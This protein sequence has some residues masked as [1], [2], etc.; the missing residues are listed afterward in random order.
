MTA[1]I[2]TPGCVP[3]E[4]TWLA[5]TDRNRR[6]SSTAFR[7]LKCRR[8][9]LVRLDNV[10]D[11][12]GRYYPAEY[13]ELPTATRLA[14]I[15]VSDPFKIDLVRRFA[16]GGRLMEVGPAQGIFAYQAKRAG[17][18]VDV[19]EM[20]AR[21]C[22]HLREVVG[23]N[24]I[25]SDAPQEVLRLRT[26]Y[27]VIAMWHVIEHVPDPWALLD[28]AAQALAPG[29]ILVIA[30]PNPAA[31]QLGMMGAEWPHL[32]A[33]RH[34]YLLPASVMAAHLA[35]SGLTLVHSTST[36]AD[37][38]RWNRFGWQRLLMNRL[39]G[40]WGERAGFVIG[41]G[42][43]ALMAPFEARD[44]KGSAYTMGFRRP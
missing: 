18:E 3:D 11:D 19:I 23:V 2:H 28:A 36:D 38:R 32:D 26:G 30:A 16:R 34:L 6:L 17:F 42:L 27:D 7:Y 12:L 1:T 44:P 25:R 33:P 4:F 22:D 43:G 37:A 8:C 20:D 15:A 13:Y 31:W 14:S 39:R 21:C 24:V 35:A 29:G 40:A 41:L 5:T 10:P 9:D